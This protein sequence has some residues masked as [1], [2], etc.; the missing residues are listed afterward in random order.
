M[1]QLQTEIDV[2]I[3]GGQTAL[4]TAYF[5]NRKKIS[6]VILDDQNQ[7][8]GAWQH[9]WQSLRFFLPTHGVRCLVG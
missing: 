5:L 9:T 7:A 3:I 8:G 2:V 1:T 6:F 4:S